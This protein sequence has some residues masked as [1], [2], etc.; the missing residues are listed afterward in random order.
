MYGSVKQFYAYLAGHGE[1]SATNN[2][3]SN[4]L[5]T[6]DIFPWDTG[7][8]DDYP[9]QHRVIHDESTDLRE[10]VACSCNSAYTI[11]AARILKDIAKT[12]ELDADVAAYDQDIELF[13]QALQEH[14]WILNLST[15]AM[16]CT[17]KKENQRVTCTQT[18]ASTTTW[19]WTALC[20]LLPVC[21]MKNSSSYSC[22]A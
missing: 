19:V 14:A 7:G 1:G 16:C 22:L 15:L 4:I 12:L 13:S 10:T 18:M 6:W 21:V 8:W 17:T 2:L 9:A 3:Q 11:R 20:L 5:R